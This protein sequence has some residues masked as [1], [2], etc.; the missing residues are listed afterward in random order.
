QTR[1]R[2]ASLSLS[3][4]PPFV[5]TIRRAPLYPAFLGLLHLAGLLRPGVVAALQDVVDSAVAAVAV[6]LAAR[7]AGPA[8]ALAAALAYAVHPGAIVA[9]ASLLGEAL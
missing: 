3:L 6:V 8:W 7:G 4:A 2:H 1:A 5:P 9:A